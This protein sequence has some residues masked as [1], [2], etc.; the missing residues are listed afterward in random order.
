MNTIETLVEIVWIDIHLGKDLGD[1]RTGVRFVDIS[2]EDL[3]SL[4]NF[5]RSLSG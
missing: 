1:Y 4:K 2:L 5:I 3:N